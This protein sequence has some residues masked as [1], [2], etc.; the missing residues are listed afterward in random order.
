M[1]C[2]RRGHFL[3]LAEQ[4]GLTGALT[5]FVLDRALS[6]IGSR[7]GEPE[8]AVAVNLGPPDL[9][10]LGLPVEVARALERRASQ[11]ARLTLEVS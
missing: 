8:L 9:L 4:S 2:S 10:D 7:T 5:A 6:E 11:A 3:P 1:V